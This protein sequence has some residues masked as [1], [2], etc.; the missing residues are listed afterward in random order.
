MEVLRTIFVN[1][2]VVHLFGMVF[3]STLATCVKARRPFLFLLI[4]KL[5]LI[6]FIT[7]LSLSLTNVSA[8]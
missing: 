6:D 7:N 1:R 4:N 2:F 8:I 3:V 5:V